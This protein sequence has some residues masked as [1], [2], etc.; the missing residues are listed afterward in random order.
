MVT[1]TKVNPSV[2]GSGGGTT[3]LRTREEVTTDMLATGTT[4]R[5][6]TNPDGHDAGRDGEEGQLSQDE[7]FDV[8][9]N[10]RRRFVVHAL[11]REAEP[12][13]VSTLSKRVTAWELGIEPID[14][15]YEDRRNVYSTLRRTHIPKL[16]ENDIVV[17]DEET[18]LVSPTPALE[19]VEIYVEIVQGREIPWNCY[20]LGLAGLNVSLLLAVGVGVP[21]FATMPML[22]VAVFAT[23]VFGLS[24]LAH[25]R[26]GKHTRFGDDD[27]PPEIRE[28]R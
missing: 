5:R 10:R 1:S 19:D 27:R 14:V 21:G 3:A 9:S 16:E 28:S 25:Y 4:A 23:T 12:I 20:Y 24:A 6:S 8:L 11:K 7:I 26:V 22:A 17:L 15:Q 2:V 13:D 18:D